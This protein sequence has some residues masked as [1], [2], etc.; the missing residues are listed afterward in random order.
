MNTSK[1]V[2]KYIVADRKKVFMFNEYL[3]R[4]GKNSRGKW[5]RD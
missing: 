4:R 2:K 5:S 3:I 1:T